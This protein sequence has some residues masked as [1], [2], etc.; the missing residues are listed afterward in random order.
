MSLSPDTFVAGKTGFA[1]AVCCGAKGE[2]VAMEQN[3]RACA[4]L[5]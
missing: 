2:V 4:I 1:S 5:K 3:R